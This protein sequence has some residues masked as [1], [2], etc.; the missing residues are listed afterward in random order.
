[1]TG[2][3][4]QSLENWRRGDATGAHDLDRR[5][6]AYLLAVVR[7]RRDSQLRPRI[8]SEAVVNEAMVQFLAGVREGAFPDLAGRCEIR[9][10]LATIVKRTLIGEARAARA[11]KRDVRQE[12]AL[13]AA[14]VEGVADPRQESPLEQ[15]VEAEAWANL[16][17]FAEW[18]VETV[19]DEHENAMEILER[20]LDGLTNSDIATELKMGVRNV[21]KV[22]QRMLER[23]L[24]ELNDDEH[25]TATS[26]GEP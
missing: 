17:Q 1:M 4:T 26:D 20:S 6:R 23:I 16:D 2:S 18:L 14:S 25:R 3:I 19:R 9:K 24:R 5:F 12:V 13:D 15:C 21:Q 8:D 10:L 22:K 11:D 7:K